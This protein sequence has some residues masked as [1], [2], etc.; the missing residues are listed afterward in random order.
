[1]LYY[2]HIT[3]LKCSNVLNLPMVNLYYLTCLIFYVS[4]PTEEKE[5]S[6]VGCLK[7]ER[8]VLS[9]QLEKIKQRDGIDWSSD[10]CC[11]G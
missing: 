1:M 2:D 8:I 11:F 10:L 9:V 6:Y 7:R 3:H 5:E 4:P